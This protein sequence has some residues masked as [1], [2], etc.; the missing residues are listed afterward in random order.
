MTG[1]MRNKERE[2]EIDKKTETEPENKRVR[3][4]EKATLCP[5]RWPTDGRGKRG[6]N[7]FI[8]IRLGLP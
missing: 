2:R 7:P 5:G 3:V 4:R 6:A 8:L 1:G